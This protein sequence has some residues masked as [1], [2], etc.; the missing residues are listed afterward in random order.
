MLPPPSQSH[1]AIAYLLLLLQ[2][3]RL[4]IWISFCFGTG[5][6]KQIFYVLIMPFALLACGSDDEGP[7]TSKPDKPTTSN[8][9]K[10]GGDAFGQSCAQAGDPGD[11]PV[12]HVCHDFPK[13]GGLRCTLHCSVTTQD[14]DC[15][16]TKKCGGNDLCSVP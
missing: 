10:G 1:R 8:P 13:K 12:P 6:K 4:I 5:M 9:D 11:C 16:Q 2:K 3:L 7:S 15:P 14:T